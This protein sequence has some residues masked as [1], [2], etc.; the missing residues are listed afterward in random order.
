MLQLTLTMK[1]LSF[2]NVYESLHIRLVKKPT[3]T[4]AGG[5][6]VMTKPPHASHSNFI[7]LVLAHSS[8]DFP[9]DVDDGTNTS[10]GL[11]R[12]CGGKV[13]DTLLYSIVDWDGNELFNN[14]LLFPFWRCRYPHKIWYYTAVP[15]NLTSHLL[16]NLEAHPTWKCKISCTFL[17]QLKKVKVNGDKCPSY[18][19]V[20]NDAFWATRA[21][22]VFSP[23]KHTRTQVNKWHLKWGS[24]L[25][26]EAAQFISV[27]V[28]AV[29]LTADHEEHNWPHICR[30]GVFSPRHMSARLT[31]SILLET[32]IE[33]EVNLF[34]VAFV[35]TKGW[36]SSKVIA[37]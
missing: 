35:H 29:P 11:L 12:L 36:M 14:V 22:F 20:T 1:R 32:R 28:C 33:L 18:L 24:F 2:F 10:G 9:P 17:T 30:R 3:G 16:H 5:Q 37:G 19:P 25:Y 6:A 34:Y 21:I 7:G 15:L 4:T 31:I 27:I 8:K 26:L 13:W 23:L